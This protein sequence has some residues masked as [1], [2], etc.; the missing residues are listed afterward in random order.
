MNLDDNNTAPDLPALL[1]GRFNGPSEFA[2]LI[3][4]A[5]TTAAAC[6]WREIILSDSSFEDWPLGERAVAQVHVVELAARDPHAGEV[7][8]VGRHGAQTAVRDGDVAP[9][10][11]DGVQRVRAELG[12][13][14]VG[15]LRA[16]E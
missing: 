1:E 13:D 11:V 2:A 7:R 3:R 9:R 8:A 15:E 5:F 6:G 14:A 12:Q 10:R 16:G 4:L